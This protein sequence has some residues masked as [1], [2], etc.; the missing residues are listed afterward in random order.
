MEFKKTYD[1]IV[2]D[3]GTDRSH[4]ALAGFADIDC[5]AFDAET[6]TLVETDTDIYGHGTAVTFLIKQRVPDASVLSIRIFDLEDG[7]PVSTEEKLLQALVFIEENVGAK[8]INMSFDVAEP[9]CMRELT[10]ITKKLAD[11]GTVLVAAFSNNGGYA[12]PAALEDV[13]GV[14]V[15]AMRPLDFPFGFIDDEIINVECAPTTYRVPW[16]NGTYQYSDGSSFACAVVAAEALAFVRA[17][18]TGLRE[19]LACFREKYPPVGEAAVSEAVRTKNER[20]QFAIRKAAAFPF[21]KEMHSVVRY[22]D[23]LPFA[24]VDVYDIKQAFR[25]GRTTNEIL[26]ISAEK[27]YTVKNVKNIDWD[28][29]DTLIL[30]CVYELMKIFHRTDFIRDL[31]AQ[32]LEHGKNI[33]AFEDISPFTE[34]TDRIYYPCVTKE[35]TPPRRNDMLFRT[36]IP[37]LGVFGTDSQQGKFT[38]QMLLRK[39]FQKL[40]CKVGQ[41]G[42]EPHALLFGMDHVYANGYNANV[43]LNTQEQVMYVNDLLRRT[44]KKLPDIV[45]T[46]T[47]KGLVPPIHTNL[48]HYSVTNYAFLDGMKPDYAVLTVCYTDP[49]AFIRRNLEFLSALSQTK[50]LA[51]V[52]FP[53]CFVDKNMKSLPEGRT[54]D[55][56]DYEAFRDKV[57]AELDVPV[58]FLNDPAFSGKLM[59]LLLAEMT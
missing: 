8:V 13:I 14:A 37:V 27:N 55:E 19:V 43:S 23:M 42:T 17:G 7:H 11:R 45:I 28:S 16:L 40:G 49:T 38:V 34:K 29:F 48:R 3:S 1:V 57:N 20:P 56:A 33:F 46:G 31:I 47:Q 30:G 4:P 36:A 44:C 12:Y 9:L 35:N 24:L 25:I 22:A 52:L 41:I 15:K 6:G 10:E 51:L 18:H 39:E 21:N 54:I 53:V 50:T 32:A 2:L 5:A 59:E 58:L 26:H